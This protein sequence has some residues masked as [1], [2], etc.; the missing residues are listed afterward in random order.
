MADFSAVTL[1]LSNLQFAVGALSAAIESHTAAD[2]ALLEAQGAAAGAAQTVIE[3]DAQA[4]QALE[5]LVSALA[6][7]GVTPIPAVV[8]S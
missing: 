3:A 8:G 5:V 6:G 2:A 1:A 7:V 4:D